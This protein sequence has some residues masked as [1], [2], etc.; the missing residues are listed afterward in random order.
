ML[1][2]RANK[3]IIVT[4][5]EINIT[6]YRHEVETLNI[7][8]QSIF[9]NTDDVIKDYQL[10]DGVCITQEQKDILMNI[11]SKLPTN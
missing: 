10:L 9:R 4:E 6:F 8:L 3:N 5:K 1:E 11:L 2:K 7:L